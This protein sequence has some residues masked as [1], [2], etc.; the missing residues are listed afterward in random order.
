MTSQSLSLCGTDGCRCISG[1]QGNHTPFPTNAW[2]FFNDKDKKKLVKAGFATPRG[3]KKGAYQNHVVRSNKVIIPFERVSETDLTQFEDG[4]SIRLLPEQYFEASGKPK[5]EFLQKDSPIVLG[6]NAFLLYRTHQIFNDLPPLSDWELRRLEKNGQS[7]EERGSNV[8]DI[9]HYLLRIS[10]LGSEKGRDE[11]PPQGFFAPEYSNANANYLCKCVLAWLTIYTAYSPYTTSQA[12][13][14]RA[15]LEEEDLLDADKFEYNGSMRRGFCSCPLCSRIIKHEELHSTVS[16]EDALG[17]SNAP[18]QI[19]GST[20]STVVNLFHLEPLSYVKLNHIPRNV[21]WGHAICNTRLGQ[22]R[23]YSLSEIKEMNLKVGIIL[24]D[25]IET[26]G[27]ISGDHQ[28]IRSPNGAVWIQ[29]N[30]DISETD[31]YLD[32]SNDT[33]T[34]EDE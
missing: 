27:W 2:S 33:N 4:Y 6:E 14:L 18:E 19:F 7:V 5:V 31:E 3:G 24:E 16:F 10:S 26:F 21:A 17:L 30:D 23:C 15:I 8:N 11:G 1:H 22:R 13:H 28:M 12:S 32:L 29:L 20:R 25:S 9:G 34:T